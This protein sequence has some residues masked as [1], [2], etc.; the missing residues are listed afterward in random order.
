MKI[1]LGTLIL[2]ILLIM[3][4][5]GLAV[6]LLSYLRIRTRKMMFVSLVFSVF[7]AKSV[8]LVISLF[9]EPLAFLNESQYPIFFDISVIVLILLAGLWK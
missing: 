8:L 1:A 4:A 3:A 7:L 6:S 2:G 5:F 9:W